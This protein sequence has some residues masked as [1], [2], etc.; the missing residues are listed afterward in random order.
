M[1]LLEQN[2]TRKGRVDKVIR[3]IEFDAEDN[4]GKEYKMVAIW[5]ST[6]YAKEL[7]LGHLSSLYH[8][9]FWERYLEKENI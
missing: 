5:K 3:Q 7:E 4:N 8:L 6:V 9:I 1:L 2:I